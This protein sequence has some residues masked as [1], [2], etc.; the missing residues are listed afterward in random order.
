MSQGFKKR[1]LR[2]Y[3]VQ[4][5]NMRWKFDDLRTEDIAEI[6]AQ[7][8]K[9]VECRNCFEARFVKELA[10]GIE[11]EE[12]IYLGRLEQSPSHA[13][14]LANMAKAVS[15]Q[16]T[17]RLGTFTY[18][19]NLDGH[20]FEDWVAKTFV[21]AG[22]DAEVTVASG[23]QGVDV[24]ARREGKVLAVQCKFYS[25]PVGNKA[26]QEVYSG[27]VHYQADVAAVVSNA[28]YTESAKALAQSTGVLLLAPRDIFDLDL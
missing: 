19:S 28:G 5:G 2:S 12:K 15:G 25:Q 3:C 4:C 18:S 22:W 13:T 6:E 17:Q 16:K 27:K 26:V 24:L 7:G 11:T 14:I 21:I 9:L 20:E 1:H 8:L 10:A 23:D